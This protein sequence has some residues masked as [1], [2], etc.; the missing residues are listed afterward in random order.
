MSRQAI[1]VLVACV[2]FVP[3]QALAA[4]WCAENPS[5]TSTCHSTAIFC[6]DL[7][8][9]C[10]GAPA[11]PPA[12]QQ[13]CPDGTPW[14]WKIIRQHWPR[15]SRI[16]DTG[17]LCGIEFK[18]EEDDR[19]LEVVGLG[20][21]DPYGDLGQN[22]VD[23]TADI[24]HTW[25]SGYNAVVGTDE[26]PLVLR[27]LVSGGIQT[28]THIMYDIGAME[29]FLDTGE[30]N[31]NRAPMDYVLVGADD[32]T[33]C[34]NCRSL[35]GG[36]TDSAAAP[37]PYVCQ[38]YE[39][40]TTGA[41][42]CPPL[43]TVVRTA[44]AV[45]MNSLLDTNPCHCEKAGNRVPTNPYLS[46]YDGLKWR[47]LHPDHP[48]PEGENAVW[49]TTYDGP[50]V[51]PGVYFVLG[52]KYNIVTMT[53][54]STTVDIAMYARQTNING[55]NYAVLSTVTGLKRAYL[56][57]F[58]KLHGG[59][60][61]GC[62]MD[63]N[64]ACVGNRH[65]LHPGY[66]TCDGSPKAIWNAKWLVFDDVY[67]SGGLPDGVPGACC[68]PGGG[69]VVGTP[70]DCAAAG[71]VSAGPNVPCDPNPCHGACCLP[72][73]ECIDTNHDACP[74]TFQG[75][76]SDCATTFCPCPTPSV[77]ADAD[78]DVD[79]GD[80]AVLQRCFASVE[81]GFPE[82]RCVCFDR[83]EIGYPEGDGDIDMDDLAAFEACA[84][85]PGVPST[86]Q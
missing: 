44:I 68:L 31:R 20:T 59:A 54:K 10:N 73:A 69:C 61:I 29:L 27:Y 47:V 80:F 46:F 4:T 19:Y 66:D 57:K 49:T 5:A 11:C 45:G 28:A 6:D 21:R 76:M 34:I 13:P 9:I 26:N 37:W 71:G 79:Q 7:E 86:C 3:V 38:S 25:G 78:G 22:T 81:V 56:G 62:Q 15:T 58:N 60:S 70:T 55:T 23:L 16:N 74:G 14:S 84:S 64:G 48:G 17:N 72:S 82:T 43:Q 2:L 40:G 18:G 83:P 41:P 75:F 32:G 1:L 12:P 33:G 8:L 50:P 53:I 85:G 30:P 24:Q 52:R 65:C 39:T 36:S 77:D 35:C 42:L 51:S 67:V 63:S